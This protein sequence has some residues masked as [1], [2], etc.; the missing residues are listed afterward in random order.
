MV[1]QPGKLKP[2][3]PKNKEFSPGNWSMGESRAEKLNEM[4]ESMPI[5]KSGTAGCH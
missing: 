1:Y 5:W 3:H 2:L 4:V